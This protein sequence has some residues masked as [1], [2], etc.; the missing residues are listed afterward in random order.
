MTEAERNIGNNK[1]VL[2]LGGKFWWPIYGG[3]VATTFGLIGWYLHGAV[4]G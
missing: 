2:G 1:N 3:V 4:P